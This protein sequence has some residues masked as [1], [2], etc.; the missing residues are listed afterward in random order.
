[1]SNFV[2]FATLCQTLFKDSLKTHGEE[3][4][5]NVQSCETLFKDLSFIFLLGGSSFS[6]GVQLATLSVYHRYQKLIESRVHI[7]QHNHLFI[8]EQFKQ[9]LA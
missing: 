4:L 7:V 5:H 3:K 2:S 6:Y 8:S 1:M 9:V